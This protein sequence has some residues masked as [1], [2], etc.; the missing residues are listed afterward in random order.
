MEIQTESI[1]SVSSNVGASSIVFE[2]PTYSVAEAAQ[3]RGISEGTGYRPAE[4]WTNQMGA[5]NFRLPPFLKYP[6]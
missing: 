4:Q 6:Y 2:F 1:L 3:V 5:P